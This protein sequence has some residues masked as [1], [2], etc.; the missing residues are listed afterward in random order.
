MS[1]EE[2]RVKIQEI[3]DKI[4]REYQPE[5]II[6]FGS[7]AW[8]KPNKDSDIDLFIVKRT[9]KNIFERNREVGKILFGSQIA[10]DSLVYTPEQ[11]ERR[12]QIGDP[13]VRKIIDSG[14]IVYE[15]Q[16]R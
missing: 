3:T 11:F 12:E 14:K 1:E 10:I 16:A 9:D 6:L 13:F 4:V 8:G 2:V 7:Y 5:K 15:Q